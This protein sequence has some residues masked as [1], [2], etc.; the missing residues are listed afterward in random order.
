MT[1]K[2]RPQPPLDDVGKLLFEGKDVADYLFQVPDDEAQRDRLRVLLD[3]IVEAAKI[4]GH[5]ELPRI[6]R[7]VRT[8]LA[9]PA[10]PRA[11]EMLQVGFGRMVRLWQA[12]RSGLF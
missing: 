8:T 3:G 5:N 10:S 12:A 4:G 7:E 11:A 1:D 6:A 2:P 9:E